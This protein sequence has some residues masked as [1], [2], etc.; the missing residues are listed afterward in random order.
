MNSTMPWYRSCPDLRGTVDRY[1]TT[2]TP[3]IVSIHFSSAASGA[4][5]ALRSSKCSTSPP[6]RN[7][8]RP[9]SAVTMG[10]PLSLMTLSISTKALGM[11]SS[12]ATISAGRAYS[13]A[14]TSASTTSM[15]PA[16]THAPPERKYA[17]SRQN[18]AHRP[19]SRTSLRPMRMRWRPWRWWWWRWW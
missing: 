2:I 5:F 12:Q 6:T 10:T 15:P 9:R 4:I 13:P 16:M 11:P 8:I 18:S 7:A 19:A 1:D 3:N 17:N 14:T